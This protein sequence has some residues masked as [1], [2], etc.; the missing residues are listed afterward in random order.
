MLKQELQQK[1]SLSP[2]QILE[3]TLLQLNN[4]NLEKYIL[5]EFEKNPILEPTEIINNDETDIK[6]DSNDEDWD[7]IYE[8]IAVYE[9]KKDNNFQISSEKNLLESIID[10]IN[11]LDLKDWEKSIA[12]EII[13][14]LDNNGYLS[15]DLFLIADRFG[16]TEKE[17]EHI[18]YQV[19]H[20]NPPALASKDLQQCLLI[21]LDNDI[22]S[23]EYKVISN[24]FDDF[25]NKRYNRICKSENISLKKLSITIEILSKLNPKP[26][27]GLQLYKDETITPDLILNKRSDQWEV[28]VNDSWIP[29]INISKTYKNMMNDLDGQNKKTK[30]FLKNNFNKAEWVIGAIDQRRKT[31]FEVMN[32]IIIHQP[33]FFDGNIEKLSPMRLKDISDII[34]LDISTVS[35]ATRGKYVETPYGIFELKSFFTDDYI[36]FDGEKI[37]VQ[38]VKMALKKIIDKEELSLTLISKTKTLLIHGEKDEIVPPYNLLEAK[39]FFTRNNISIETLMIKDCD[40]HIPVEASSNALKFIKDNFD[41]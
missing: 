31:L 13:Y 33:E 39:D 18:L 40:H 24:H 34:G 15:I 4:S 11:D 3:A 19:Q 38:E 9:P 20:L 2:K 27:L 32:Q 17:I 23:P 10:Q 41:I 1:Q 30:K 28:S 7:D 22:E 12:E 6:E 26:G 25:I 37:S 14:N 16:K 8:S 29:P 21:Q 36:L 5:E 35:R